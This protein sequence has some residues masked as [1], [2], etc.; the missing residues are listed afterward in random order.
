MA[1]LTDSDLFLLTLATYQMKGHTVLYVPDDN[2]ILAAEESHSKDVIQQLESLLIHWTRQIKE[3]INT[4]HTTE[5]SDQTGPLEEIQFWRSRCDDLSGIS[6]QLNRAEVQRVIRILQTSTSSYLDQFQRLS[7]LIHE[8]TLQAQDNL[9]FLSTLSKPCKALSEAEP[10]NI[11]SLLPNILRCV[12]IIWANSKYYN[13]KDRMTSL[14]RKVSNEIM[15]RCCAKIS[16][17]E[18]FH[19][20]VQLSM[21]SL[22]DSISCG[23]A[24]KNIY[25]RT[26]RHT[27][28]FAVKEWDFDESSIFAQIDAFV[29][30][31][32]D[33][34]EVCEGQIQFARKLSGGKKSP[35]PFFGGSRGPEVAKRFFSRN[36][37]LEDIEIA[38]EKLIGILWNIRDCILDVKAIEWHD[39]YN[40]FKQGIKD[41]EVMM[42]NVILSSFEGSN[43][44]ESSVELLDIFHNLVKREAIKRTLEKK[45]ADVYQMLL[46]ELN[47]VKIDFETH[48]KTPDV[49]RSQ[50]DF[51]GSAFWAKS[52]LRRIQSVMSVLSAAYFLPQTALSE[53]AK[54][55]FEHLAVSLE[56][57]ISKTHSEWVAN[58][59]PRL[60][61]KLEEVL[62]MHKP[63]EPLEMKFDK[64]LFRL[65][66]EI[67]YF[68]KLKCDSPF[69]IQEVYGKK[70]ELRILRENVLLVIRDY[71]SIIETLSTQEAQLFKERIK[72]LDR[73]INPGLT[74]LTWASKGV[75][76]FFIKECRRHSHDIQKMVTDFVDSD[77]LLSHMCDS[78]A[79]TLLWQME[80]KHIYDLENFEATQKKHHQ[81]VRS[82]LSKTFDDIKK[83]L[84]GMYDVFKNDGREVYSHW[85]KYIQ[86]IDG[87]IEDAARS[88]VKKSLLEISKA[89]NGEGKNRDGGGEIHPLFK[90]NVILEGQKV[91]FSPNFNH[92][93]QV[94]NRTARDMISTIGVLPRLTQ[95][96]APETA[97]G[98]T[99]IYDVVSNEEDIVKIFVN[100]QNGMVNNAQKCQSYLSNWDSY[101][102]IWEINKDAF[103]RR[104]EKLKPPLSTFDADINRYNEVSNNTQKEETLTNINFVR[105]DC[106]SLKNSLVAHCTQWQGKLTTLL[107]SNALT[108]L[109]ALYDMFT[110]KSEKLSNSPKDLE[111]LGESL[112]LL[113]QL[114][115]E[116]PNI[117]AQ[118]GPIQEMYEILEKYEGCFP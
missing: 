24:W 48:R 14:L 110:K 97:K 58:I 19:G 39:D 21:V 70:E 104:Y 78:I 6:D 85:V 2:H 63:C 72:F 34:L 62:M 74:N 95:I 106:S 92:L 38:F 64:D 100:I 77:T 49:V 105:L 82:S 53:E 7:N 109:N 25:K 86:K 40:N 79:Y 9:K 13:T 108:E 45:T 93:E 11:I 114:Q 41:L 101:R 84:R 65:Y 113:A 87:K 3:V 35:I 22:Q 66:S 94:V 56:D 27:K 54:A 88:T 4:Q 117:E 20:D 51:A 32:R 75:T 50:P 103:I 8:G 111:Q 98:I 29:Q 96:L 16:L 44:I 89:I 30:R 80:N 36:I 91:D 118:F 90:V 60:V 102:E 115:A 43:T 69:H 81:T 5:S 15:R 46:T 37:S 47:V 10:K 55:Q 67:S 68:Q 76:E 42:Q 28:K 31:C 61:E 33:L 73:K 18:I 71:N 99:K 107:N 26:L 1:F 112:A 17:E 12:R 52:L 59:N 83:T 116:A 57:Y 23:D